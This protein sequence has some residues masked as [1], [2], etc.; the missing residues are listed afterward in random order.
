MLLLRFAIFIVHNLTFSFFFARKK[1][2]LE[3][4]GRPLEIKCAVTTQKISFYF[5]SH[6]VCHHHSQ[7][8]RIYSSIN[9]RIINFKSTNRWS[10]DFHSLNDIHKHNKM[11]LI[12]L[13]RLRNIFNL[14]VH[15]HTFACFVFER[16]IST[17]FPI[18]RYSIWSHRA[19]C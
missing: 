18:R 8:T 17:V 9:R 4:N 14:T 7:L 5:I 2:Q 1:K 3:I 13:P 15:T 10:F 19:L 12:Y 6:F 16:S 11:K